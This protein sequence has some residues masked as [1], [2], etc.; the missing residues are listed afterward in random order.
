M[1]LYCLLSGSFQLVLNLF[2]FRQRDALAVMAAQMPAA[3]RKEFHW[4]AAVFANV[5]VT[6]LGMHPG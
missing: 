1:Q 4:D 6:V 3:V 5:R 2:V